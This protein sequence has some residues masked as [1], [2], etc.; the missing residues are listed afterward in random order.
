MEREYSVYCH[1]FP[2][3]KKYIGISCECEKRW[4][5]GN[6]YN[7]QPKMK[8]AI[9]KY[10]WENI[11]H[12]IVLDGLSK[13]QANKLEKYLIAELNTIQ[14]GYNVTIGADT[15]SGCY[16]HSYVFAM[17]QYSKRVNYKICPV[18]FA[19]G[20]KIGMP[21]YAEMAKY[22]KG[23]A[24]WVNEA[25]RAVTLKHRKYSTTDETEVTSFWFHFREYLML[26]LML[27]RGEDC[28]NW[29]ERI[30]PAERYTIAQIEKDSTF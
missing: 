11:R 22:E 7:S 25:E 17:I 6:G 2:N 29:E 12:D 4:N 19:D 24:E 9:K 20:T 5:N 26:H 18:I 1:T 14:N 28:S 27:Q 23:F 10:G 13:E 21:E 15:V 8:K 3:G 16:L 30:Y